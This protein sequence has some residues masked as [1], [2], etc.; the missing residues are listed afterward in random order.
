[1]RQ[2]LRRL[3]FGEQKTQD[4]IIFCNCKLW[5][6]SRNLLFVFPL[7][8]FPTKPKFLNTIYP[9][10]KPSTLCCHLLQSESW[11]PRPR[12]TTLNFHVLTSD[13]HRVWNEK[14]PCNKLLDKFICT[15]WFHV[16]KIKVSLTDACRWTRRVLINYICHLIASFFFL[17]DHTRKRGG[18]I[19]TSD[20]RFM[21][22][23]TESI[24][25]FLGDT[26]LHVSTF[27]RWAIHSVS[28][29]RF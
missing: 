24:D 14:K 19:R 20:L 26:L 9:E 10:W 11:L 21:K 27:A 4:K 8:G 16:Q 13:M 15:Y 6:V 2:N 3:V 22:R 12:P 1:M 23:G 7:W 28:S 17:H 18:K 29:F 5:N 25:L